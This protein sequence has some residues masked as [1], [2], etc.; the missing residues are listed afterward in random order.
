MFVQCANRKRCA[1]KACRPVKQGFSVP[2]ELAMRAMRAINP[3]SVGPGS[4][5]IDW[6]GLERGYA[7]S[8]GI[9]AAE[10]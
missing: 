3:N 6:T 4:R 8:S 5:L 1:A 7:G 2:V 9:W 10:T